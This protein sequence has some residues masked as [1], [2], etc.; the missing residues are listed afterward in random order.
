MPPTIMQSRSR[1]SGPSSFSEGNRSGAAVET[2]AV[3]TVLGASEEGEAQGG[4]HHI[5]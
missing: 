5:P 3:L 2:G 1:T 4:A